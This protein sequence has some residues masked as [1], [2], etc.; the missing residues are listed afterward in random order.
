MAENPAEPRR[1]IPKLKLYRADET[2]PGKG[3]DA[4]RRLSLYQSRDLLRERFHAR[5]GLELSAGKCREIASNLLQGNQ[6][7]DA[8]GG[9][10]DLVR[11]L[12]LYYG[13]ISLTRAIVLFAKPEFRECALSPAHGIGIKGWTQVLSQDDGLSRLEE[14]TLRIQRGTFSDLAGADGNREWVQ[15]GWSNELHDLTNGWAALDGK[16]GWISTGAVA[17]QPETT[18]S[19]GDVLSRI[20]QL[21]Y[22]YTETMGVPSACLP[23]LRATTIRGPFNMGPGIPPQERRIKLFLYL[24]GL[25]TDGIPSLI[26][27]LGLDPARVSVQPGPIGKVELDI[28]VDSRTQVVSILSILRVDDRGKEFIVPVLSDGS[29]LSTLSVA[30]LASYSLGMMARYFPTSWQ[31]LNSLRAGDRVAPLLSATTSYIQHRVPIEI[32]DFLERPTLAEG[33]VLD[34]PFP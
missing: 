10:G 21:A 19:V 27:K 7:F 17:Y 26:E 20:P 29:N 28:A 11:P 34:L 4:W 3:K 33:E 23:V 25:E 32:A 24:P 30:F 6:Y 13:V 31:G 22:L 5:H 16:W 1:Q 9:S 2:P 8:A 12:L 18:L 14:L 15:A